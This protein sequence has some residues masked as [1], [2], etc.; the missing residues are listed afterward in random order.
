MDSPIF[1]MADVNGWIMLGLSTASFFTAFVGVVAGTAGG[2]ILLGIMALIFPPAVLI[3]VHTVVQLGVGVGRAIMMWRYVL[4]DTMLP[5]LIGAIVGATAGA[6][7]FVALP[8]VALQGI[9]GI[10]ILIVTWVPI[11]GTMGKEKSR[12]GFLGFGATF[13]GMFVSATGTLIAPFVAHASPDRRNHAATVAALMILVHS[14]K[15]V[16]FGALGVAV[17]SYIPLMAAM[18]V[19]ANMGNWVG[20]ITLDH[21]GERSFRLLFQVLMTGLALRLIWI[22]AERGGY[23]PGWATNF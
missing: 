16:A 1:G 20:R 7:L 3:P 8:T 17:G 11:V 22:A 23:L 9:L 18:I 4:K 12:F 19:T 21:M 13:L 6:Q 2:L 14:T 5:F 10:F 15:V